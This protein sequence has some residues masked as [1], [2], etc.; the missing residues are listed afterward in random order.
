MVGILSEGYI[1]PLCSE[2]KKSEPLAKLKGRESVFHELPL[3][4]CHLSCTSVI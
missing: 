1:F 3:Y 4:S 2:K